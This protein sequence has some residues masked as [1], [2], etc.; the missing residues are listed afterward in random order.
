MP[1]SYPII[2]LP[3][4]RKN[5]GKPLKDYFNVPQRPKEPKCN[6]Y[7]TASYFWLLGI[8]IILLFIF[9]GHG[10][11]FLIGISMLFAVG[12]FIVG[13]IHFSVN[14]KNKEAKYLYEL[15]HTLYL[16]KFENSLQSDFS[17]LSIEDIYES[18]HNEIHTN[19]FTQ[20]SASTTENREGKFERQFYDFLKQA[21]AEN[22]YKD[23]IIENFLNG[24]AYIPDIIYQDKYLKVNIDI[25]VDEPYTV[26][27]DSSTAIHFGE[28]TLHVDFDRD[29][30]F[31]NKG[32]I[33]IRFSERQIVEQPYECYKVIKETVR[34]W[35]IKNDF[36]TEAIINSTKI[37]REA[38]WDEEKGLAMAKLKTRNNYQPNFD[39]AQIG[40]PTLVDIIHDAELDIAGNE[41]VLGSLKDDDLPF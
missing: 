17:D 4:T 30:Y 10:K 27:K 24:R 38:C 6:P 15:D 7:D 25:E 12:I 9:S 20:L 28:G 18:V 34:S 35:L 11:S 16:E 1:S 22:F 29:I 39:K 14:R 5:Y 3:S 41:F 13:L 19:Q 36:D 33:V 23:Y 32:W 40:N 31:N 26:S 21:E 8:Y 37:K 2:R